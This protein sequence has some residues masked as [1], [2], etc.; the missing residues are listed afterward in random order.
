VGHIKP[1]LAQH[2]LV[3]GKTLERI[4]KAACGER[5]PLAVE[6]GPGRG[7][8]TERLLIHA[9]RVAAI[10]LDSALAE[11]LRQRWRGES[12]LEILEGNGL[13]VD[14]SQWGPGVLT[15]NLPYYVATP[16]VSRYVRTPGSL[17]QAVFLIQQEVAERITAKPGGRAYGY[18]SVACQFFAQADYLFNVPPGAFQPPPKVDS[19]VIRLIPRPAP[20]VDD[21][22]SFLQFVSTCFRQKRKTLRNNLA[23]VW[24]EESYQ[25]R[26]EIA[27][28]AEQLSVGEFIALYG[29][30]RA[31]GSSLAA[32]TP[33]RED[34][35]DQL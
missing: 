23:G 8:L 4:A 22:E 26:P 13:A 30:L 21:S 2:F 27:R 11:H 32:G 9:D 15:G 31:R 12:R 10:E 16:I 19:A 7:A 20:L 33:M 18:L 1:K 5:T 25:A 17:S 3:K 14:W 35:Q 24:P 34:K 28:R 6:I 29:A